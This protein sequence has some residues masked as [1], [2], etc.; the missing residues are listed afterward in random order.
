MV[1]TFSYTNVFGEEI[2]TASILSDMI[3]HLQ[4]RVQKGESNLTD[5]NIGSETRN[6]F[7]ANCQGIFRLLRENDAI[8]RMQSVR[9]ANG[10][11]L[12]DKGYEIGLL[13]K[14]GNYA[15]GSVTF[16]ISTPLQ[17][18]YVIFSGTSILNRVTGLRYILEDD[19]TIRAG[20]TWTTGIVYA[21][22]VGVEYNCPAHTLTAFDTEQSLRGDLTVDNDTAFENGDGTES[23]EDFR[24][25]ILN[26]MRG[27]NFGSWSY[28]QRICENIDGVH[29]VNFVKPE[30]LNAISPNR[31]T[32]INSDGETVQCNECTAVCVINENGAYLFI[33][34]PHSF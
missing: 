23:D 21:E 32:V 25:R 28:Y 14:G 15:N 2:S 22:G 17:T 20:S 31:H 6:L 8:G 18:D 29:D 26:A 10:G 24:R 19:A 13:R 1:N 33:I 34:S 3:A 11:Y 7:E 4:T 27:G 12:D 5:V 16:S 30:K 9:L